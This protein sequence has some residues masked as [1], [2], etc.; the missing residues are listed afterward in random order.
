MTTTKKSKE[1]IFRVLYDSL[2]GQWNVTDV[3]TDTIYTFYDKKTAIHEAI[4]MSLKVNMGS[5][6]LH[7]EGEKD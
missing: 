5:I 3:K 6:S 4:Q 1:N 7:T 2:Q